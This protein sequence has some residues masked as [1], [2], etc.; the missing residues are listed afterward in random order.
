MN[1]H[2]LFDGI[3]SFTP[4][5]EACRRAAKGKR[6]KPRVAAFLTNLEK[7]VLQLECGNCEVELISRV[8]INGVRNKICF[9]RQNC[10]TV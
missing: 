10:T 4:L 9:F 2:N 5:L 3:A 6:R 8:V 1:T 7:E